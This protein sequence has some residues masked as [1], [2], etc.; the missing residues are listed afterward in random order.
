MT[1]QDVRT[2]RSPGVKGSGVIM[3]YS[4]HMAVILLA[5]S[6]WT[7]GQD[8]ITIRFPK[9][10]VDQVFEFYRDLNTNTALV[11]SSQ[12][13]GTPAKMVTMVPDKPVERASAT[14]LVEDALDKQL[15][16]IFRHV[17]LEE[18]LALDM[19]ALRGKDTIL[20]VSLPPFPKQSSADTNNEVRTI[21][22]TNASLE[23]FRKFYESVSGT[24]VIYSD[25]LTQQKEY[26]KLTLNVAGP[27]TKETALKLLD[28]TLA[29]Q[30][31]IKASHD[32]PGQTLWT[33][34]I[35]RRAT[36]AK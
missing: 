14:R 10:P 33:W 4:I 32:Q 8:Q 6:T 9:A 22:F 30:A 35:P 3:K 18:A 36:K 16:I 27:M 15:G 28:M 34:D 26:A 5:M 21:S 11:L 2:H 19:F 1:V 23:Q 12:W 29:M 17:S 13:A 25:L 20:A 31:A 24:R 7:H